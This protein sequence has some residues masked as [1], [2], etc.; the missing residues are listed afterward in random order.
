VHRRY[1]TLA[2]SA[3]VLALG[4]CVDSNSATDAVAPPNSVSASRS[5]EFNSRHIF[6]T[7]D[8]YSPSNPNKPRSNTGIYYHGGPL[9]VNPSVTNVVAIYWGN[10][11]PMYESGPASGAGAGS[12]DGSLIGYF[13]SNLGGSPYFDI[14]ATYYN[15]SNA[16]VINAVNYANYW[17]TGTDVAPPSSSP[18]DAN[19]VAVI[20]AGIDLGRIPYD[21]NTVYAILTG[22]GINLGGG[23][24]SQYCAYH[25]HGTVTVSGTSR[26]ALYAAMPHNQDFPSGCTSGFPS[27]NSDVAANSEANTLAHEIEETTTDE[28]GTAWYDRRGFENADKC[29]WTWG[30]L[31]TASNGGIYN[32]QL[33]GT[34][35]LIQ[36]NWKNAA[37][38]GCALS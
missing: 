17:A 2:A 23:F 31:Q 29:A 14:N 13:L 35:F 3:A 32:M 20:Q 24:G 28:L 4:A 5:Q 8:F 10:S 6:H 15:G 22:P 16:F 1:S 38:G 34:P 30:T 7:K 21:P 36:R 33:G 37:S 19:M 11:G 26:I 18:T 12:G 27:P 9:I 25:T